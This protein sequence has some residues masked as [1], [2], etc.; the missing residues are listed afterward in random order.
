[1]YTAWT[2]HL[3][4]PEEK[5]RFQRIVLAAK[6]VLDHIKKLISAQD[7]SLDTREFSEKD[8][9]KPNW[10]EKHAFRNGQRSVLKSLYNL[11]D[12]DQ[13]KEKE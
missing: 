13:Q 1:M 4:D 11:I 9:E 8:F 2:Q 6:P 3:E 12:L 7:Q 10:P 5:E